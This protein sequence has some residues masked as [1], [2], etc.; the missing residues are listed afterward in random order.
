MQAANF[1]LPDYLKRIKFTGATSPTSACLRQLMRAQVRAIAFENQ[2]V[3]AGKIVSLV[4]EDIVDKVIYQRRGGYC[5]EL[6]GLF[7]MALKAIG[8]EYQMLGARP[9]FY[10]T[11]RPKTHV[12][13]LV[14]AEGKG[15]LC[16]LGFGN[17]G[18][19]EPIDT[20][21]LNQPIT[22]DMDEF[23]L[24]P[25]AHEFIV[26]AKVKNEWINQ[27][28]F[29]L[30]PLEW[31]DLTLPNYFNST[32]PDTIFVQKQIAL[33]QTD[34]GRKSLAG[35][36][37]KEFCNGEVR[38]RFVESSDLSHCLLSEFGLDSIGS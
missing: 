35:N 9:M 37:F 28:C 27:F 18:I 15:W 13:L 10:P 3:Q 5:Y 2:D 7:A 19:R 4:P 20:T 26:K 29:D 23:V 11:R 17:F 6:N 24:V 25:D 31:I 38:E 32:H 22:Q 12:V 36:L 33:I 34:T 30:Y 8:F 21:L 16:D 1:K 14:K